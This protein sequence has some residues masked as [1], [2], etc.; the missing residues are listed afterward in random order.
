MKG[1]ADSSLDRSSYDNFS[2]QTRL[3]GRVSGE[4]R[5]DL[6]CPAV[7]LC[8]NHSFSD[9]QVRSQRQAPLPWPPRL[10]LF[11][12]IVSHIHSVHPIKASVSWQVP[13]VLRSLCSPT[14]QISH[15]RSV[16]RRLQSH[17]SLS[18]NRHTRWIPNPRTV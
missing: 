13:L 17:P 12:V 4:A 2:R 10:T 6:T 9:M 11:I 15:I 14:L 18:Q 1:I 8:R 3:E 5:S 16:L 7:F